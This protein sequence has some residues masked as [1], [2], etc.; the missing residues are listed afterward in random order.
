MLIT[1]GYWI[2]TYST[3]WWVLRF[4]CVQDHQCKTHSLDGGVITK[5]FYGKMAT[6][7]QLLR[8]TCESIRPGTEHQV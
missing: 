2:L 6:N 7:H 4:E 8:S 5:R 1:I 3:Y